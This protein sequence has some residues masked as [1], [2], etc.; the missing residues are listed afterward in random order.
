[1][2]LLKHKLLLS[3]PLD[4][5][6]LV[7]SFMQI[8]MDYFFPYIFSPTG[9]QFQ[10][11]ALLGNI[12]MLQLDVQ[13]AAAPMCARNKWH[14]HTTFQMAPYIIPWIK[15]VIPRY[16]RHQLE[17]EL[18]YCCYQLAELSLSIH[19]PCYSSWSLV[20]KVGNGHRI[21]LLALFQVHHSLFPE[22]YV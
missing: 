8:C 13:G 18:W 22:Y 3:S 11:A 15:S 20:T 16:C 21:L 5:R 10:E 9:E 17:V 2:T 12:W 6:A 14:R 1:M 19:Q 7:S 4:L